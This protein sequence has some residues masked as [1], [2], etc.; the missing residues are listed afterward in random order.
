MPRSTRSL[1]ACPWF[2]LS[3]TLTLL[4][5]VGCNPAWFGFPA[6]GSSYPYSL[7]SAPVIGTGAT[8]GE[9]EPND[10]LASAGAITVNDDGE[11]TIYA[12]LGDTTDVDVFS[13]GPA[14]AGDRLVVTAQPSAGVNAEIGVFDADG[15]LLRLMLQT[16]TSGAAQYFEVVCRAPMASLNIVVSNPP[17]SWTRGDYRLAVRHTTGDVPGTSPQTIV[18]DF[19]GDPAVSIGGGPAVPVPLFDA[20][21][22][23]P[24]FAG[25]TDILREKIVERVR[26]HFAGLNVIV[27]TSDEAGAL[28]GEHTTIYF[29]TYNADLLGLADSVDAYNE[30]VTQSAII[31]TDTFALFEALKPTIDELAQVLA[32]VASHEAGHLLGLWH[33]RD[34]QDLMD[35]TA[36]AR[37]MLRP[38]VFRRA[39]L[40]STV[41]S[42]GWQSGPDLLAWAVGGS[43]KA[44]TRNQ[45]PMLQMDDGRT[46]DQDFEVDRRWLSFSAGH[47]ASPG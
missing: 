41:A 46:P 35:I 32:N 39:P 13:L 20:G 33:T 5:S 42:L 24:R 38:Q 12:A 29:G 36:T 26:E 30:D 37:Q 19:D 8:F 28:S 22:I 10:D 3:V 2:A 16:G 15:N 18:L 23:S 7:L 25:S 47:A 44:D 14:G 11:A 31:F 34:P 43:L 17:G 9:A 21:R 6:A 1:R 40:H 27:V 45:R 4:P